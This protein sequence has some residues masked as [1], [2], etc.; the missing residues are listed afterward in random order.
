M[1]YHPDQNRS[2]AKATERMRLVNA[3]WD[4]LG[5]KASRAHYATAKRVSGPSKGESRG[6]TM[7]RASIT[8]LRS[9]D[10]IQQ[11]LDSRICNG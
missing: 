11:Y 4:I 3:A 10:N 6:E 9:S 7:D 5:N 1:E 2:H 8:N